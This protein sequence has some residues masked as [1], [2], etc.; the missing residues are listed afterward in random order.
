[1]AHSHFAH[2]DDSA[3]TQRNRY[4]PTN[5]GSKPIREVPDANR[6]P[7]PALVGLLRAAQLVRSAST[8]NGKPRSPRLALSRC[9]PSKTRTTAARST[10]LRTGTQSSVSTPSFAYTMT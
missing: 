7:H 10:L 2:S 3:V 9:T 5:Y 1:M 8:R 4:T 6:V